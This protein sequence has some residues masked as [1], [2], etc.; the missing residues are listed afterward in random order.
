MEVLTKAVRQEQETKGFCIRKKE[1]KIFLL[2][3]NIILH[4]FKFKKIPKLLVNKFI[5]ATKVAQQHCKLQYQHTKTSCISIHC[6]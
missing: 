2:T 5:S 3:D 1:L 6:Q 4:I